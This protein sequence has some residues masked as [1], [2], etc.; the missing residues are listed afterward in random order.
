MLPQYRK[1]LYATDLSENARAAFKHAVGFAGA[2]R[3]K[4]HLVHV[5]PPLKSHERELILVTAGAGKDGDDGERLNAVTAEIVEKIRHRLRRFAEEELGN[6]EAMEWLEGIEVLEG[7]RPVEAILAA[8]DRLAVDLLVLGT[9]SKGLLKQTL[10]GSV[11][12]KVLDRTTRPA[13]VVP[14]VD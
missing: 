10:L 2:Y 8:A 7:S 13:L 4:I 11:A 14:L 6:A 12:E 3:A 5:I 9:H 1:I